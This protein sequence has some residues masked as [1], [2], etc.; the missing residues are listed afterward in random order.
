MAW[1][2]SGNPGASALDAVRFL[3]G[4]TD[5][6]VQLVLDAEITWALSQQTQIY[7]AG[8]VVADSLA[9]KFA[10][11]ANITSGDTKVDY[12]QRATVYKQMAVT[13]RLEGRKR[14]ATP[15]A[16]GQTITDKLSQEQDANRVPGAFKVNQDNNRLVSS[17]LDVQREI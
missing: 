8:A 16:G 12:S 10:T 6:T 5:S 11:R 14:G 3:V 17:T 13:L 2:Y 1:T 4:D 9:R 15:F 7:L